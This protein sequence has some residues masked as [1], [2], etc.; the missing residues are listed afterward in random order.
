M[1]I[2]P[3]SR[4]GERPAEIFF[5]PSPSCGDEVAEIVG[6]IDVDGVDE[7]LVG[8]IAVGAEGER[9][10]QEEAQRIDAEATFPRRSIEGQPRCPWLDCRR[11]RRPAAVDVLR[12]RHTH[13]LFLHWAPSSGKT[14]N[15]QYRQ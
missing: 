12:K 15:T 2:S 10:Q 9:A 4:L 5:R 11:P 6:Q 8:E 3:A 14:V 13:M 1:G 7:Q